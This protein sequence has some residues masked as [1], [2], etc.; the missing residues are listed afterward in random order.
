MIHIY[1]ICIT[2]ACLVLPFK[3]HKKIA[4]HR[5]VFSLFI[6]DNA[7]IDFLSIL[8]SSFMTIQWKCVF[9]DL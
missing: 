4:H 9:L 5:V 2:F 1:G 8:P 7:Q 3:Q 6:H